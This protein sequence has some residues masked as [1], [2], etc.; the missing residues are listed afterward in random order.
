MLSTKWQ[1]TL[2]DD[3]KFRYD[4]I[5]VANPQVL[6]SWKTIDQ[7]KAI[8]EFNLEKKLSARGAGLTEVTFKKNGETD[9][10]M[11]IWSGDTFMD[12]AANGALKMTVKQM[13]GTDYLFIEKGVFNSRR[14][15]WKPT[16][17]VLKRA[18]E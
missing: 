4:G 17:Y 11:R 13:N 10:M 18:A 14:K 8:D 7:V 3:D 6:G 9:D 16:F 1:E 2:S 5:F 12:L 15:G